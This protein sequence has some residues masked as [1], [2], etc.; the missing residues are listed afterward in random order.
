M[1]LLR[2]LRSFFFLG[3]LGTVA[4]V[5]GIAGGLNSIFGGSGGG[6][7][8]PNAYVPSNQPGADQ[9]WQQVMQQMMQ[10]YGAEASALGPYLQQAF[11]S[12]MAGAPG[13]QQ[14]MRQYGGD[15]AGEAGNLIGAGNTLRGAGNQ[16]WQ[17]AQDPQNAL[18]AKQLQQTQD[19]SRAASSMR[20]IGMGAQAAGLENDAVNNFGMNWENQQLA[21]QAQGLQGMSSAYGQAGQQTGAGLGA[22][23]GSSAMM[24]G[25]EQWPFQLSQLYSGA[26]NSG[27]YQ[28][29]GG[30]QGQAGQYLGLG[31]SGASSAFGQQQTGL[32]NLTTGL[33]Q[34]A[35]Q[36]WMQNFFSPNN[37][38]NNNY[39][40]PSGSGGYGEG[41]G[42]T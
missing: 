16:L 6:G 37:P 30:I 12:S 18:Y 34:F 39:G 2:L 41:Y 26:L 36:P 31:Q 14:M 22:L 42:P 17:T 13:L 20:G 19:Q 10:Q 3:T 27:I 40:Q 25:A 5:V 7:G 23:Q 35:Q 21:R 33:G 8:S 24:Q 29:G 32:N 15:F 1:R 11:G 28:P 9:N 4:S 38:P